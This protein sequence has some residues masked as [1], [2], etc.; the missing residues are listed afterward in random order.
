M[1]ELN[2]FRE[3]CCGRVLR[4]VV[5]PRAIVAAWRLIAMATKRCSGHYPG[6]RPQA[7]RGMRAA[8]ISRKEAMAIIRTYPRWQDSFQE[9]LAEAG[10][11]D[12]TP[13]LNNA[14]HWRTP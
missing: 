7:V 8:G 1:S 12:K 9:R 4:R 5:S 2:G 13:W 11:G 3:P 6:W 10:P 14:R